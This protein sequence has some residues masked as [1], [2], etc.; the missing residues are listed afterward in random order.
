M[1]SRWKPEIFLLRD[2]LKFGIKAMEEKENIEGR[3]KI[4]IDWDEVEQWAR[5][6]CTGVEIAG[7]L[8]I[9]KTTLYRRVEEKFGVTFTDWIT[10]CKASGVNML[11]NQQFK[12]AAEGSEK[13][14][15]HL[16]KNYADQT[17]KRDVRISGSLD[18]EFE[19]Y[20]KEMDVKTDEELDA[21]IGE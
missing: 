3:S 10:S 2:H 9:H 17:D 1:L 8:G 12:R 20:R 6:Q 16:G 4:S 15:I 7:T 13:M 14:L 18:Q 5:H 19:K 21:E 11:K